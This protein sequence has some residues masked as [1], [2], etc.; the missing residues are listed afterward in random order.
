MKKIA[1]IKFGGM[2][3]GGTEKYLQT[4]AIILKT[5]NIMD[6]DYYYTNIAQLEGIHPSNSD[7]RLA[8]MQ[9]HNINVIPV[10]VKEHNRNYWRDTDLW[11]KFDE[12]KYDFVQTGRAGHPEYPFSH[13]NTCPIID[14]IHGFTGEDKP[15]IKKA[16]LLCK[17]QAEKWGQNGGNI[18]KAEIIP[19]I[20]YVPA[21]KSS[22]LRQ[23]LNIPDDVFI[24]GFH[25]G[26]RGDIFS[27]NSLLAYK[28]VMSNKNAFVI[29]G[30]CDQ[31]KTMAKQLNLSNVHFLDFCSSTDD[32]HDFLEGIDVFAHARSDGEV[33]SAAIIEALYHGKPVISH[34]AL[35]MGHLEQI[36]G[37]G[38]IAYNM[39]E[40]IN[41][42]TLLEKSKDYYQEKSELS[43]KRYK[44]KYDYKLVERQLKDLYI[45]V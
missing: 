15:N 11:S 27:P 45:N 4:L 7:E 28:S 32:I 39:D 1:F 14:S 40:Y 21:I 33:C 19:S 25:Q 30:G 13:I 3:A 2:A 5:N 17:W 8:L 9:S 24:Y 42:M 36:E 6:I 23:R 41:E 10:F 22:T 43:V 31:H 16:I 29:L 44:E 20:V 35:N 12:S 26:N 18:N 38:R 37:C 34:P